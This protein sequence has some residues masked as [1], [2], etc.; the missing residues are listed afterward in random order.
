MKAMILAAGRGER[1][2][3]LTDRLPKPLIDV[4]GQPLIAYHLRA[5]AQAG[6]TD[7][8]INIAYRGDQIRQALGDGRRFGVQIAYSP[9]TP[10]ELDTGGG[11]KHALPLLGTQPFLLVSSDIWT[12]I[13]FAGLTRRQADSPV[14]VVLVDNPPHHERGDFGLAAGWI[15]DRPP[16]LTYAGVGIYT[17]SL[18]KAREESRFGVASVIRQAM[19]ED[20]V[21]GER[22]RGRWIDVGRPSALEAAR[23]AALA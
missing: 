21:T 15:N 18:F 13:D 6:V 22:H 16:R 11:I 10:G 7:V 3:P 19:V 12:D 5:L 8:V 1:L 17:P 20:G 23:N 14:H 2:R 9:E 4:G